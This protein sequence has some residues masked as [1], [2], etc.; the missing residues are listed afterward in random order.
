MII[1]S[2]ETILYIFTLNFRTNLV[3]SNTIVN[4]KGIKAK[5]YFYFYYVDNNKKSNLD[6]NILLNS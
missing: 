5:K 2:K 3:G 4:I 1:N 6:Y